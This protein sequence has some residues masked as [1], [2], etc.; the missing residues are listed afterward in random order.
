VPRVHLLPYINKGIVKEGSVIYRP[1]FL[2]VWANHLDSPSIQDISTHYSQHT[3]HYNNEASYTKLTSYPTSKLTRKL[4]RYSLPFLYNGMNLV[5]PQNRG[6]PHSLQKSSTL[7][8]PYNQTLN[9]SLGN[10][11]TKGNTWE[12]K[13]GN[14]HWLQGGTLKGDESL[15]GITVLQ[16]TS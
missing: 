8:R 10:P 11:K 12:E 13:K 16:L 4:C 14:C 2:K 7:M 6:R 15:R 3:Y 9:S 1:S 5:H